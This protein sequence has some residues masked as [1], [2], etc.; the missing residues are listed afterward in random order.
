MSALREGTGVGE[1]VVGLRMR[2]GVGLD[3]LVITPTVPIDSIGTASP[4]KGEGLTAL[5]C[6]VR[7]RAA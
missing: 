7:G 5:A 3:R 1:A 2:R 6:P 4:V